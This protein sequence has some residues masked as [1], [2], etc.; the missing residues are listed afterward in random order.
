[1]PPKQAKKLK[2]TGA[3][4]AF[5]TKLEK[6]YG[7]KLARREEAAAYEFISTG[8]IALDY[9]LRT[10]GFL[11]GRMHEIVGI[12][13]V[14]KTTLAIHAMAEHQ[15]KF[16][17]LGIGFVDME[18]TFDYDWAE[19]NGLDTS[20]ERFFHQYPAN[21]EDA[22]DM[23][24]G[25]CSS[26]LF[27]CA[28]VDS[29][30]SMESQQALEKDADKVTMGRNAQVITR[31]V[32]HVAHLAQ[33][34]KTTVLLINQLRANLSGQSG[35]SDISA[36]PKAL[37][38]ATTTKISMR[39]TGERPL[40]VKIDGVDEEISRQIRAKVDRSKVSAQGRVAEFWLINQ[41][42]KEYGPVGFD[43]ADEALTLGENSKVIGRP[44]SGYYVVPDGTKCHGRAN[45]LDYLR[46]NPEQIEKIRELA[47]A[48]VVSEII[49]EIEVS[50][51]SE[52]AE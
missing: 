10:G 49:P 41:P 15:R 14:G 29:I 42:T 19:A 4:T 20:P 44:S 17:D 26:P 6:T 39:R 30:G 16:P 11:R 40:V 35:A 43:R 3:L 18:Q 50:F 48:G 23:L 32:K 45:T 8:S 52:G 13:G 24:R 27:S 9:A 36:G 33:V 1:M 47:L 5:R 22:S 51:E 37:K 28:V 21:A 7:N 12:E 31:M 38:Y 46:I 34:N 25:F 2:N